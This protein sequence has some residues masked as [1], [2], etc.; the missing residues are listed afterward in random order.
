MFL[1]ADEAAATLRCRADTIR[2][3]I[4]SWLAS[5]GASDR[6]LQAMGGWTSPRMV[7][8]YAH[9]RPDDTKAWA[10]TLGAKVPAIGAKP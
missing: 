1:T 4:A 2:R 8:R 9:L 6:V 10:D 5:E 3:K 7:G